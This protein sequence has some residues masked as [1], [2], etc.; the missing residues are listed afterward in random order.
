VPLLGD[1]PFL[2]EL[3]RS[4]ARSRSKTNLMVFIRPTIMRNAEDARK[5]AE[6][7]YGY[8]R[9][10]QLADR[11]DREPT[12]DE[13]LRDYMGIQPPVPGAPAVEPIAAASTPPRDPEPITIIPETRR[14]GV[15]RPVDL[16]PSRRKSSDPN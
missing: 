5:L 15:I 1:I 16:P 10:Q 2:G 4:R 6:Q 7:R 14:S 11:P 8:I 12:I 3:F 13:L 9:N